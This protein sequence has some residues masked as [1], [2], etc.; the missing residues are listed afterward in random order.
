MERRFLRASPF[1]SGI[2][3]VRRFFALEKPSITLIR[4]GVHERSVGSLC[5][6]FPCFFWVQ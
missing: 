2:R 5:Q 4:I 3:L 6:S 1:H